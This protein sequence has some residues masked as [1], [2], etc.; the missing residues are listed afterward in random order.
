MRFLHLNDFR[1]MPV[2]PAPT[3][4]D[5]QVRFPEFAAIAESR[6]QLFLNDAIS[7]LDP[8]AWDCWYERGVMFHAAHAMSLADAAA[9]ATPAGATSA[10]GA[11]TSGYGIKEKKVGDV[12]VTFAT[13]SSSSSNSGSSRDS[14]ATSFG[15]T[16]YG[17]Q[18]LILQAKAGLG[19]VTV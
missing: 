9:A 2:M 12:E 15:K 5:F 7:D 14:F 4:T 11:A 6:I 19:A 3:S 16:Y 1:R 8:Q 10:A 18:F 13:G 17:E